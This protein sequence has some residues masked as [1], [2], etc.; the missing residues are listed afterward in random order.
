MWHEKISPVYEAWVPSQQSK[1]RFS[2]SLGFVRSY[3]RQ[4]RSFLADKNATPR[5]SIMEGASVSWISITRRRFFI[6]NTNL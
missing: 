2:L 1:N 4:C 6:C 3:P 5:S